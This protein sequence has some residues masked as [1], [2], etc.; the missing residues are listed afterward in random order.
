MNNMPP[1]FLLG[2]SLLFWGWQSHLLSFAIPMAMLLEAARSVQGRWVFSDKDFNRVADVSA[3]LWV[4]SAFYLFSQYSIHGLFTLLNWLPFLF[5]LLIGVQNYSSVGSIKLSSLFFSLRSREGRYGVPDSPR[6]NICYPYIFICILSASAMPAPRFF[7]GAYLLGAWGLWATRPAR[8][9]VARWSSLLVLVAGV[10]YLGQVGLQHLQ[11]SLDDSIVSWLEEYFSQGRDPYRQ[12]TALG[13]IGK[14]KQSDRILLRVHSPYPLLLREASYNAYYNTT[15]RSALTQFENMPVAPDNRS[16]EFLSPLPTAGTK[17]Q[18]SEYLTQG[19]GM[20]ALPTGTYKISNLPV[21]N[22]Q[23]NGL[24]AVKVEQG[25]GLVNYVAEF[26]INT[27]LD[28][29]PN[30]QDLSIPPNERAALNQIVQQLHLDNMNAREAVRRLEQFFEQE[31]QYSLILNTNSPNVQS[32]LANFLLNTR[33]GHCEFFATATVLLLRSLGIPA[34]YAVG[35]AVEEY[36][37]LEDSYVVR[38]RHAHAWT[39]Y[40]LDGHWQEVDT[41]PAGWEDIEASKTTDWR[42]MND[43]WA[44]ISHRFFTWK[45]SEE[46]SDHRNLIWW[47]IPLIL[48]LLWRLYLKERVLHARTVA[49]SKHLSR[50]Y[51]GQDSIFYRVL[52]ALEANNYVRPQEESLSFWLNKL[53]IPAELQISLQQ[54]WVLHQ[55]YRFDPLG[56]TRAQQQQFQVLAQ[57]VLNA[58]NFKSEV[59]PKTSSQL[60][61]GG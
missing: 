55:R 18:I 8:Y 30:L 7:I 29:Q 22:L 41:T 33:S 45:W 19:K 26:G 36:S 31:F 25:L 42:S 11:Q 2:A 51:H 50:Q 4:V 12:L 34:R 61:K 56:L 13:E 3:L 38:R 32:P 49:Q 44:W 40:H 17:V 53:P 37:F 1:R 59:S 15:W 5:F 21:S 14:L 9:S 23:R 39:L 52:T 28:T 48:I 58:L 54:L 35:Y 10:A 27:P 46:E 20:L 6:I 57:Q 43:L 60:P 16:W 24:G 47:V